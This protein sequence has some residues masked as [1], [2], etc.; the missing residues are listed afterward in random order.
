MNI[1]VLD[2]ETT[3]Q[4]RKSPIQ[5]I[6]EVGAVKLVEINSTL[7]FH[8]SFQSYV[9]PPTNYVSKRDREFIQADKNDF[10]YAKNLT[11][12]MSQF[13]RWIG[14]EPYYLCTWSESD[15]HILIR[16][17]VYGQRFSLNWLKNYNDLQKIFADMINESKQLS[18]TK[19]LQRAGLSMQGSHHNAVDDAVNTA[20]ILM[21]YYPH[22]SLEQTSQQAIFSKFA[23]FIYSKCTNCKSIKYAT[24]YPSKRRH[25]S[26]RGICVACVESKNRKK[27][28]QKLAQVLMN[29]VVMDERNTKYTTKKKQPYHF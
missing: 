4:S 6:I 27:K 7:R 23:V 29:I 2:L 10:K 19:S 18:L 13:I 5:H 3:L 25:R 16:N 26:S 21:L 15:L 24:Q 1:I 17:Y 22:I 8:S 14:R 9:L 12:V 20:R 28:L 11:Y